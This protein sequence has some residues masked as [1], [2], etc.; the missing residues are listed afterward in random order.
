[1]RV[2]ISSGAGR[3]RLARDGVAGPSA[4]RFSERGTGRAVVEGSYSTSEPERD[5]EGKYESRDDPQ[6]S[7][8]RRRPS[9][10]GVM[11]KS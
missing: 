5:T 7:L 6:F 4:P 11:G 1:M 9:G 8:A 2:E 10:G 3:P